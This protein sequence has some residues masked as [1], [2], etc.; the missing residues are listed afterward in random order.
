[1]YSKEELKQLKLDFWEGFSKFCREHPALIFK[2]K[3]WILNL[4]KIS[5]VAFRFD[6][7]RNNAMVILEL[8]HK[9]EDRRLKTFEILERYKVIVEEGFENGLTWEYYH[10][11]EDN[12]QEVCRIYTRLK[13]VDFHRKEQWPAIYDFYFKNMLQL[14]NN[15]LEVREIVQEAL[16]SEF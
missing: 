14:E 8:Q 1:M 7:N 12:K 16:K 15:F 2:K 4:T 13:N 6:V 5:G 11:R 10:Q 3:K 9:S